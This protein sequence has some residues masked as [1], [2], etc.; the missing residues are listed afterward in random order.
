MND[1]NETTVSTTVQPLELQFE[2]IKI[3]C[4][5]EEGHRMVPVKTVCQIIGVDYNRQD[6]WLKSHQFYAQLYKLTYTV[7][8]DGKRREMNCL[9]IFDIDGWISSIGSQNR[10]KGSIDKQYLFL[11][12]L[13]EQ[14]LNM[15]KSID[16]FMQE[17]KYEL[18]LIEAKED[19]LNKL[20]ETNEALKSYKK[21][22]K[23]INE[24]IEEVRA[25]RFTGQTALPFPEDE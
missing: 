23:Q 10:S 20:E 6:S 13:R 14:K 2:D 16:L 15:Y 22:L 8:A 4:P 1:V 19:L 9:S 18:E 3:T 5:L 7:G 17:N 21:G 12:W 11:A 24:S 25:K